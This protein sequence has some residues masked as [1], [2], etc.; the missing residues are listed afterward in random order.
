MSTLSVISSSTSAGSMPV[1]ASTAARSSTSSGWPSWRPEMLM[2]T[3][4]RAC[5]AS[6]LPALHLAARPGRA[7][8]T[9]IGTMSPVSSATRDEVAGRQQAPL[10]VLPAHER[11]DA[12]EPPGRQVD[13][14]LVVDAQ[15]AAVEGAA[16]RVLDVEAVDRA[17]RACA[18]SNSSQRAR[19][20]VLGPVHRGVGVADAAV[21]GSASASSGRAMPMLTPTKHLGVVDDERA[22]RPPRRPA[23][24][25]R[26]ASCWLDG[27][28]HSTTNSSP[29][30]RATVS[31]GRSA[32]GEPVGDGD[33]QPV[34]E[35]R[36]RGCR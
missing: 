20:P 33:Q 35:R 21:S 2:A 29:P 26:T 25:W 12:D 3:D 27:S 23:R 17:G 19:P 18:L 1:S 32:I 15:L 11:L 28:S 14:R 13:H 4:S 36:G 5:C 16:Q 10:G 8:T 24:R 30:K 9:P 34:A 7:P 6:R 31:P 22:A